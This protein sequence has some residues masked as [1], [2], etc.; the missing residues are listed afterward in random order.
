[1]KLETLNP[2]L[3]LALYAP[4]AVLALP[5]AVVAFWGMQA[6]EPLGPWPS[7]IAAGDYANVYLDLV[8]TWAMPHMA[9]GAMP[10]A[11]PAGLGPALAAPPAALA[12]TLLGLLA[13]GLAYTFLAGGV[14]EAMY[15]SVGVRECGRQAGPGP[16][17]APT[18]KAEGRAP[19]GLPPYPHTPTQRPFWSACGRWFWPM[20]R[21]GIL[22]TAI[23]ALGAPAGLALVAFL[24]GDQE[25]AGP[26]CPL[27]Y[28][29]LVVIL[30][31]ACLNGLLELARANLVARRDMRALRALGRALA[32]LARPRSLLRA[33]AA[34]LLLA[35]VSAAFWGLVFGVLLLVPATALA[36]AFVAQQAVA[37]LG[38]WLKLLRL[39]AALWLARG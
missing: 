13:Q 16:A 24:P 34:W 9:P 3:V 7:R 37:F 10:D 2:K 18:A 38:A 32:L 36:A 15:G 6:L 11:P 28:R 21:C 17:P 8:A 1:M 19:G 33:L 26:F 22:N 30:W 12:L 23:F 4:G 29:L 5:A 39:R 20:L 31:L 14:L 35:L 25:C 27:S